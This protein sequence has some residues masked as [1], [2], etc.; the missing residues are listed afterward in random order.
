MLSFRKIKNGQIKDKR[1]A[2]ILRNAK[3]GQRVPKIYL[4]FLPLVCILYIYNIYEKYYAYLPSFVPKKYHFKYFPHFIKTSIYLFTCCGTPFVASFDVIVICT[5]ISLEAQFD[6]LA[7]ELKGIID[8]STANVRN[9]VIKSIHY[10]SF[11]LK[12]NQGN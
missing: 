7:Y 1:K 12:L 3:N 10:H 4:I 11:L 5:C 9:E 8:N 2:A 6:L